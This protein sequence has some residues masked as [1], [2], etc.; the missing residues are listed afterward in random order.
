MIKYIYINIY[1]KKRVN[2]EWKKGRII[3]FNKS[4]KKRKKKKEK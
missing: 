3:P 2:K 4:L 1:I